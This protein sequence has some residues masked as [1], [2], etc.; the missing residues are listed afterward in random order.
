MLRLDNI[1]GLSYTKTVLG[2]NNNLK[3]FEIM[4]LF[5]SLKKAVNTDALKNVVG[6]DVLEKL[7]QAVQ[8]G[9]EKAGIDSAKPS[10]TTG[11]AEPAQ[12]EVQHPVPQKAVFVADRFNDFD[13]IISRNF[14]DFEVRRNVSADTLQP[15]CHPACAPVQFLFYRDGSPVLAV[16]LVKTNNYR[17]MNVVATKKI[18]E[19]LGIRYIRFYHE[20]EN[21]EDY[22]VK[23]IRENL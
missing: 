5:D 19:N 18:C 2:A 20:Y 11:Q 4:G 3:G 7:G 13:A 10:S 16:V 23:R 14:P 9:M 15:G 22:V 12:P 21:A 8:Q 17:G 6:D 1:A